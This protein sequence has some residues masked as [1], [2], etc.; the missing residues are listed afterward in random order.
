MPSRRDVARAGLH[1]ALLAGAGT[2]Q[3][4]EPRTLALGAARVRLLPEPAETTEVLTLD[5]ASPGPTLRVRRGEALTVRFVNA[6]D[7]SVA[8][9][10]RGVRGLAEDAPSAAPGEAVE[11]TIRPPDA[12]VYW[13]GAGE[14]ALAERGL[15]GLLVVE[16]HAAAPAFDREATAVLQLVPIGRDGRI[17][18]D[19]TA[20]A[21]R[22]EGAARPLALELRGRERV[23]LRFA[24]A[25]HDRA[26]VIGFG[27]EAW[28]VARDG[29]DCEVH[30][31]PGGEIVLAPGGRADVAADAGAPGEVRHVV[32]TIAGRQVAVV[33]LTATAGAAFRPTPLP[34]PLRLPADP[35]PRL[36][37]PRAVRFDLPLTQSPSGSL[38]FGGAPA[39]RV[40]RG[41]T[42]VLR[43]DNRAPR[44]AVLHVRG[45]HLRPLDR[46]DDGWKPWL[47]DGA[48]IGPGA[49]DLFAFMADVAG[50]WPV[51]LRALDVRA[52]DAATRLEVT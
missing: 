38:R 9:A 19:S 20:M 3:A 14:P 48:L 7:R 52:P 36:D 43:I 15:H 5:G 11:T 17:D 4:A 22:L 25:S 34:P 10:W 1:L 13:Y 23:L 41:A 45:H 29:R 40:R 42:V 33:V 24:N 16:D 51:T 32:A 18:P 37:L 26:I 46:F 27:A 39:L 2:T 21:L 49:R 47:V 50:R 6:L 12:G 8:F 31:P 35:A 30:A 28:I 44:A